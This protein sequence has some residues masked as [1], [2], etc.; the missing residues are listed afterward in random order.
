MN[1]SE[2]PIIAYYARSLGHHGEGDVPK[3]EIPD[4]AKKRLASETQGP[5]VDRS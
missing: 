5:E 4:Y 1:E 3:V 2:R